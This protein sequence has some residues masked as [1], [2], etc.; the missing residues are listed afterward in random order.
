MNYQLAPSLFTRHYVVMTKKQA[1]Y[2]SS[3]KLGFE[4]ERRAV[5]YLRGKKMRIIEQNWRPSGAYHGFEL[6]IVAQDGDTL[7]FVEVK[8]RSTDKN[9]PIYTAFSRQKQHK[10]HKAAQLYLQS[11]G[12]WQAPCRFDLICICGEN[13]RTFTIQ[14]YE[15]VI[16]FG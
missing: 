16:E 15:H 14:H 11:T 3:Q 2:V 10:M 9:I 6:D 5:R 12:Q 8:T 4:G 7:V 1:A 13:P